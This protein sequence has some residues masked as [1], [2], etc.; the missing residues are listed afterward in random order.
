MPRKARPNPK[1][2]RQR[3]YI[4]EW[5]THAPKFEGKKLT[6]AKLSERLELEHGIHLTEGQLSRIERGE[7]P[8]GQDALEAIADIC[9]TEPASLLMRDPSKPDG[10]WKLTPAAAPLTEKEQEKVEDFIRGL[11]A[12][13]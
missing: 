3:T 1:P 13:S 4:K 9:G 10:N 12:A 8:Y 5:R 2:A 7:Q 6:L 11:R